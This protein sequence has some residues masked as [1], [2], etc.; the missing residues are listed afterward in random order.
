MNVPLV[1]AIDALYFPG[2]NALY[3]SFKAN[4]GDGFDFYCIVDG[5]VDL[6]A[7]VEALGITALKPVQWVDSY[8]TSKAWPDEIPS[9]FADLQIP[10]LFP[11]CERAIWLDADCIIV[12]SLAGL[13]DHAFAEPVAACSPD[14]ERYRLGFVLE[15]APGDLS[16]VRALFGGLL[17]FNIPEWNRRDITEQCAAV[18]VDPPVVFKYCDQSV[19]SYVL[20][21]GFSILPEYWQ[22]FA[23]RET[24]IPDDAKILHY[25]GAL[26]WVVR[27]P[28]QD[29]WD[30]YR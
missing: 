19:L 7:K 30:K 3:N 29:I 25:V 11:D 17:V 15:D 8:P 12:S 24:P 27:M 16:G 9:L 26:P 5:D 13:I 22:V 4:A 20:M 21:G 2:L 1:T 6:F 18:M 28:H 14:N 23:N 10:R